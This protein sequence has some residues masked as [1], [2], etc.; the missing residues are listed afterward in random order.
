MRNVVALLCLAVLR[1]GNARLEHCDAFLELDTLLVPAHVALKDEIAFLEMIVLLHVALDARLDLGQLVSLADQR[2]VP[3]AQLRV[4]GSMLRLLQ[5]ARG[6]HA[7]KVRDAVLRKER[8]EIA[9]LD[10]KGR[11]GLGDFLR[12]CVAAVEHPVARV[13]L[14]K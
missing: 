13:C 10:V 11:H 8:T 7:R 1:V 6:R 5:K 4:A 12:A 2:S 9:D 14:A 3:L